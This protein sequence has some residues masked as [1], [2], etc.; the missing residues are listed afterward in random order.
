MNVATARAVIGKTRLIVEQSFRKLNA[1]RSC[2][3]RGGRAVRGWD[4][5]PIKATGHEKAAA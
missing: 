1:P 4:P 2:R 3:G 5:K